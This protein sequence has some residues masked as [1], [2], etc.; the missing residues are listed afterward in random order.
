M[1]ETRHGSPVVEKAASL[2]GALAGATDGVS[3]S[4]LVAKLGVP[5][6]TVYRILNSLA[7]HG[8]VAR[9]KGGTNYGLGPRFVELARSISPTADR[10]TL[11][12]VSRP[13][14]AS[15]A[16]RIGESL[17]LSA[18][19]GDD[20]MTLLGATGPGEYALSIKLG[21]R[22]PKHVGAAGKLAL[23]YAGEQAIADYCSRGLAPRTAHTITDPD[24]LKEV[25]ARAK[26]EGFAEDNLESGPGIRAI[27][28]PVFGADGEFVAAVSVP[29][30]GDATPERTRQ[31][32]RAVTDA[33]VAITQAIG[34]QGQKSK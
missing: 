5:R 28:A 23:A 2:L 20:M 7:A 3:L 8:L 34:G 31:I 4:E 14:L 10:A 26:A 29:F 12:E 13:I 21:S 22:S 30:I 18:P 27:A 25:L 15:A 17:K 11:I 32:R 24:I 19:E 33:A 6:S 16:E 1:D 9:I